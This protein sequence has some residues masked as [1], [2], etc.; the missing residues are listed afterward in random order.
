MIREKC[1]PGLLSADKIGCTAITEPDAGSDPSAIQTT[2]TLDGDHYIINGTK[3]WISNGSIADYVIVTCKDEKRGTGRDAIIRILVEKEVSPFQTSEIPKI[4]VKSFP[5]SEL[6]F[7]DCRVP[8]ENLMVTSGNNFDDLQRGLIAARCNAAIGSAAIAE[9]ALEA[10]IR[11]AKGR[12][13]FGKVIGK[14]Q[15]VQQLIEEMIIDVEASK[16]LAFRA[17]KLLEDGKPCRSESSIAKAFA[18]EKAVKVASKAMQ[19]HG[20]YGLSTEYPLERYFRD[21][22]VYTFP[23]GTTQ[24]QQL[25]IAREALGISAIR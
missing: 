23:D 16:L 9:A 4:G 20:A 2:A 21:A 12:T 24:I 5:T 7:T 17:Y 11:Y 13:Q 18:T 10:A 8:K 25:I 19:V 1:L 15:M 14:F 3:L 22:R 6:V